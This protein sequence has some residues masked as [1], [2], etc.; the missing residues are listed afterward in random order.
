MT[1]KSLSFASLPD[2]KCVSGG[3]DNHLLG[4]F[5]PK[6]FCPAHNRTRVFLPAVRKQRKLCCHCD[7]LCGDAPSKLQGLTQ[8]GPTATL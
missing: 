1:Q 2:G 4:T 6:A 7:L 8:A 3:R 5:V